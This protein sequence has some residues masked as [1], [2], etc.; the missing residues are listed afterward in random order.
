MAIH[1]LEEAEAALAKS[2]V[3]ATQLAAAPAY[4]F[5][6]MADV[7]DAETVESAFAAAEGHVRVI[8]DHIQQ[9]NELLT[10]AVSD[11][12]VQVWLV[13]GA[14]SRQ[15]AHVVWRCGGVGGG[16]GGILSC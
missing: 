4:V 1:K 6:C 13:C 3:D 11:G 8:L 12:D 9:V 16:S 2:Q 5:N 15:W 10:L 14:W 7:M